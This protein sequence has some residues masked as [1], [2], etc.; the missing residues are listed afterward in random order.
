M[1]TESGRANQALEISLRP[2][3]A[4][5]L[6][7]TA[8]SHLRENSPSSLIAESGLLCYVLEF[9]R[10]SRSASRSSVFLT[11]RRWRNDQT[12]EL[13]KASFITVKE[14]QGLMW[15]VCPACTRRPWVQK[16]E[17]QKER[18]KNNFDKWVS[19]MLRSYL[20]TLRSEN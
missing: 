13:F 12:E 6:G 19:R 18:K 1:L 5:I 20:K 10:N 16:Q 8:T 3:E 2:E 7:V 15:D 14:V 9:F 11:K 4:A 17:S